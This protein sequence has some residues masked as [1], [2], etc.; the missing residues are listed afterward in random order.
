MTT[1]PMPGTEAL[2]AGYLN[3]LRR[4]SAALPAAARAEL[5]DDISAHLTETIGP[6]ADEIQVRQA[7]DELGTPEE[8]AAEAV[9]ESGAPARS[10]GDRLYD[11]ATVLLLLLGNFVVPVLAWIVGVVMLWNGPRWN[12]S[13]KWIGT[14]VWPVAVLLFLVVHWTAM[15]IMP[16]VVVIGLAVV[17]TE[18]VILLRAAARQDFS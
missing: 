10:S 2:I 11:V 14:L 1:E 5:L 12:T 17:V 15:T 3:R 8:I 4:A 9:A 13:Q 6:G 7:L 18:L 16:L